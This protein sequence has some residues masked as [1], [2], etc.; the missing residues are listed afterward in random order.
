[1]CIGLPMQVIEAGFGYATCEGLGMTRQVDTLL[2]G[3]PPVGS[4]VLVFLNSAR[5]ILSEEQARQMTDAVKAVEL[6]MNPESDTNGQVS[7]S[8][9][10][11][12]FADLIDREPPKP[13]SLIALEKE[14][15]K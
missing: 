10:D 2:I 13:A 6:V 9:L 8:A 11:D 4:W 3:E 14:K 1:M 12:L 7:Q 15:N 5:E